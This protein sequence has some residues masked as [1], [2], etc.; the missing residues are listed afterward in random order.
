LPVGS[1]MSDEKTS[2]TDGTTCFVT[3]L[4]SSCC[5]RVSSSVILFLAEMSM[6][7]FACRAASRLRK[8]ATFRVSAFMIY[9]PI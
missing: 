3:V 2:V 7:Q 6:A 8:A 1:I 9:L 4:N 5:S